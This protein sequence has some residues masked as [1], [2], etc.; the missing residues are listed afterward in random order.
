MPFG[1]SKA[2]MMGAAGA[3]GGPKFSG[4]TETSSGGYTYVTYTSSGTVTC[5]TGGVVDLILVGA[6]GGVSWNTGYITQNGGGGGGGV[7]SGAG[8]T[9]DEGTYSLT[10]GAGPTANGANKGG[11]SEITLT[12]ES[13]SFTLRSGGGGHGA[14]GG[15]GACS[16][17]TTGT[18]SDPS[19]SVYRSVW[20]AGAGGA[21][22]YQGYCAGGGG[23]AGTLQTNGSWPIPAGGTWSTHASQAGSAA[24]SWN[25]TGAGGGGADDT[26]GKGVPASSG[27][28][29]EGYTWLDGVM[30]GPGGPGANVSGRTWGSTTAKGGGW[31][32]VAYS[33]TG[34]PAG[35]GVFI[36]RYE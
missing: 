3:G 15:W 32:G 5:D 21:V 36:V 6:G 31:G 30:Y 8:V 27:N 18:Q 12:G 25:N 9:I 26:A 1:S 4:G 23:G 10:I 35:D 22:W 17:G 28:G 34:C 2:A 11:Y 7:I 20:G 13:S 33:T 19:T 14:Y 29:G 24:N 16:S